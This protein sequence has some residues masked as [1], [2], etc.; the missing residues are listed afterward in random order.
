MHSAVMSIP[1]HWSTRSIVIELKKL[2]IEMAT[3]SAPQL[4]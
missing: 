3:R 2:T 4:S 1:L